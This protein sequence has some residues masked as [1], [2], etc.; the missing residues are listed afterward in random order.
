MNILFQYAV[1]VVCGKSDGS[2][3]A[4]GQYWTAINVHN[5]TYRRIRFRKKVAVALPH[6]EAG[7]V[8]DFS[9]AE[10]GPD[11]AL[12]ID[13]EDILEHAHHDWDFLKGFVVIQ[14]RVE[15]DIVAV[16][17]AAGAEERVSTFHTERVPVRRL[18]VGLPD[19]LP[20]PDAQGDFCR[21]E[22]GQLIV[23][24]HNQGTA[25][26][27]PSTTRVDFAGH[28]TVDRPTPALTPGASVNLA[29]AIP[30][31]CFDPDCEFRIVVDVNDDVA[32][33]DE[34]NNYASGTCI[35]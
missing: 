8:S 1:K 23:T 9:S 30:P 6:E 15:L 7:P 35:G 20:I 26:A 32:E 21:P 3:V 5:P 16:Y 13:C 10:L 18:E 12:E 19:L 4:P 28:G 27:G 2:V 29:F 22:D 31:G 25:A 14:S 24:V 11:E 34:G 33:S 17:T